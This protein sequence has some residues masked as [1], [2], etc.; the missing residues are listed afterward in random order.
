MILSL[1]Y[2][3]KIIGL[4]SSKTSKKLVKN[5]S[6]NPYFIQVL[7]ESDSD[8]DSNSEADKNEKIRMEEWSNHYW[9]S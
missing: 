2:L 7:K 4:R 8:V 9:L 5:Q 1:F 3:L 6:S